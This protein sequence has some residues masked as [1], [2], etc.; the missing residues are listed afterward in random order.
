MAI[1]ELA[2][3]AADHE[4]VGLLPMV[5]VAQIIVLG[6]LW[7]ERRGRT[8]ATSAVSICFIHLFLA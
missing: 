4:G 3:L 1:L 6:V 7:I 5:L 2:R 8:M